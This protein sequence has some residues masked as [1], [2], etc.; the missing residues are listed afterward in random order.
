MAGK[1]ERGRREMD[2]GK[3]PRIQ[4]RRRD[5]RVNG[6]SVDEGGVP[7]VTKG[8]EGGSAYGRVGGVGVGLRRETRTPKTTERKV[9]TIK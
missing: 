8:G 1:G 9:L 2:G 3:V 4:S 5:D 7:N 6:E